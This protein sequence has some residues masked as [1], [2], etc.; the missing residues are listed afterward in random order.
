MLFEEAPAPVAKSRL[1]RLDLLF[2]LEAL[3]LAALTLAIAGLYVRSIRPPGHFRRHALVFD[4]GAG[5]AASA[6]QGSP[7]DEA[8]RGAARILNSSPAG[9]EFSIISYGLDAATV[10]PMT[11]RR[12]EVRAALAALRP[13]DVAPRPAALRAALIRARPADTDRSL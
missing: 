9:D 5:M 7:L 6:G 10:L 12:A 3:A 1:L 13:I 2:W 4:L 11:D 8:R